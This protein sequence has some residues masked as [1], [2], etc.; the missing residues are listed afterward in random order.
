MVFHYVWRSSDWL[1]GRSQG[2]APTICAQP[3]VT[4]LHLG[5][6]LHPTEEFKA[7]VIFIPWEG[8]R[9]LPPGYT[10]VSWLLLPYLCILCLPWVASVWINC[11]VC[12][13]VCLFI[14]FFVFLGLHSRHMEVPRLRS[15]HSYSCW[16]IPQPK[17][18]GIWAVSVTYTTSHSNAWSLT[19]WTR[20]EIEPT[21]PWILVRFVTAEPPPELLNQ[22]FEPALWNSGKVKEAEWGVFLINNKQWTQRLCRKEPHR[23]LIN[24]SFYYGWASLL[25]CV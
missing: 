4:T 23:A 9:T 5:E 7:M 24:F 13:F 8:T 10:I 1:V 3:E 15:N 12:L 17:Q 2:S 11:F 25:Q 20:P 22:L 19:H 16:P 6:G 18:W 21:S 14:Y